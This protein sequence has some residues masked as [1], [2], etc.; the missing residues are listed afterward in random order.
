MIGANFEIT[1]MIVEVMKVEL[2]FN[3]ISG[4][5]KTFIIWRI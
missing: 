4:I 2:I 1:Y 3:N 5:F